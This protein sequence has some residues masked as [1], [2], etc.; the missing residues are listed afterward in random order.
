ML[1]RHQLDEIYR[2]NRL[3]DITKISDIELLSIQSNMM[4]DFRQIEG[5]L[6]AIAKEIQKR[7]E[8]FQE[9]EKEVKDLVKTKK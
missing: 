6:N 2:N 3:M 7:V 5:S 9:K 8:G 4:K 1:Q